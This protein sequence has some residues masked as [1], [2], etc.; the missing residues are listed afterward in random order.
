MTNSLN[1][2]YL[3]ADSAAASPA[4]TPKQY[5]TSFL[6][7]SKQLAIRIYQMALKVFAFIGQ[8]AVKIKDGTVSILRRGLEAALNCLGSPSTRKIRALEA[9]LQAKKA[10][11]QQLKVNAEQKAPI[12]P[13]IAAPQAA[14]PL[15]HAAPV[16]VPAANQPDDAAFAQAQL[17]LAQAQFEVAQ[18]RAE[19]QLLRAGQPQQIQQQLAEIG[20]L[21]MDKQQLEAANRALG[22]EVGRLNTQ[23]RGA[24]ANNL[25]AN[26]LVVSGS[27]LI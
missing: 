2:M 25:A 8:V 7:S 16:Q 15:V 19:L 5:L 27:G 26:P 23:L 13:P 24:N 11:V 9:K 3:Q 4:K 14:V 17:D 10:E 21:R 1:L 22:N 20:Q 12:L 6:N 18:L